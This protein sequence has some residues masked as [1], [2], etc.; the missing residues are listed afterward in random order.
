MLSN[1]GDNDNNII[2]VVHNSVDSSLFTTTDGETAS[3]ANNGEFAQIEISEAYII[4]TNDTTTTTPLKHV[5]DDVANNKS[6]I[7]TKIW[8]ENCTSPLNNIHLDDS[9]VLGGLVPLGI[10]CLV[11]IV[12]NMMVMSAVKMTKKLRGATYLFIVSLGKSVLHVKL[13]Y[14]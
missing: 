11:V 5:L 3:E 1:F 6:N 14:A 9:R 10:I 13:V 4:T 7:T 2:A 8:I 12:G